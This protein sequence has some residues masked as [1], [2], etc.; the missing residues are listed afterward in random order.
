[1]KSAFEGY[2]YICAHGHT[3]IYILA[4]VVSCN[5]VIQQKIAAVKV[6][7]CRIVCI[8]LKHAF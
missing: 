3:H 8:V 1:M 7:E 6:P 2:V 4:N 5:I